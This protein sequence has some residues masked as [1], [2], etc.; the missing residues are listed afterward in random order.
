MIRFK[1][2]SVLLLLPFGLGIVAWGLATRELQ[3]TELDHLRGGGAEASWCP[4]QPCINRSP[5]GGGSTG[6]QACTA[7]GQNCTTC[8]TIPSTTGVEDL[9]E[10]LDMIGACGGSNFVK[11]STTP[12]CKGTIGNGTC[13]AS[14]VTPWLW[15]CDNLMST[16]TDCYSTIQYS[17]IYQ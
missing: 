12:E 17:T 16:N 3:G 6:S 13:A 9:W 1:V 10:P 2:L 4:L 15:T 7:A 5:N 8:M 14:T 11:S